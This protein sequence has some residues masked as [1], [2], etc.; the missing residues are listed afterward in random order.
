M[1]LFPLKI[2]G[3]AIEAAYGGG[4]CAGCRKLCTTVEQIEQ[5]APIGGALCAQIRLMENVRQ[6]EM[7][8]V[9]EDDGENPPR[10]ER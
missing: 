10:A 9:K 1:I 2:L 5:T 7:E 6:D 4:E 3:G 8:E